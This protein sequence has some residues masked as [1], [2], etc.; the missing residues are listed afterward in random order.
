MTAKDIRVCNAEQGVCKVGREPGGR[1]RSDEL[2]R[3]LQ[4][5][6]PSMQISIWLDGEYK[7]RGATAIMPH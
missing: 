4:N 7:T 1:E 5:L 3:S 6:E 2:F